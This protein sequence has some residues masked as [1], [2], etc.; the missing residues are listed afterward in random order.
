MRLVHVISRFVDPTWFHGS[1]AERAKYDQLLELGM[2]RSDWR[3]LV[4]AMSSTQIHHAVIA[5]D[6]PLDAWIRRVQRPFSLWMSVRHDRIG[7]VIAE[8][9]VA[10]AVQPEHLVDLVAY[11]AHEAALEVP[12]ERR[13]VRPLSERLVSEVAKASGVTVKDLRYRCSAKISIARAILARVAAAHAVSLTALADLLAM[14][15]H[16]AALLAIEELDD[17]ARATVRRVV[18]ALT[19]KAA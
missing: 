17:D 14:S 10:I 5:G 1:E 7:P 8:R 9:S 19:L 18:D 16:R 13:V 2:R 4:G 6:E 11:F 15:R 3:P 12:S